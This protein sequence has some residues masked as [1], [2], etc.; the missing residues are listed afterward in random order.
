[1]VKR[2]MAVRTKMMGMRLPLRLDEQIEDYRAEHDLTFTE[3]MTAVLERGLESI[4]GSDNSGGKR[5]DCQGQIDRLRDDLKQLTEMVNDFI[6]P[7]DR[8]ESTPKPKRKKTVVAEHTDDYQ[9]DIHCDNNE[10]QIELATEYFEPKMAPTG[11]SD[12]EFGQLTGMD[13]IAIDHCKA[14]PRYSSGKLT[15]RGY[16]FN[17]E[18]KIWELV[19]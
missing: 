17:K 12:D 19:I 8:V 13:F 15:V 16:Y 7:L 1:M 3:A 11:L 2:I 6:N 10:K 18:H 14:D 9:E 5:V 4:N